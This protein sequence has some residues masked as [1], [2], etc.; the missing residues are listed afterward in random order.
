M[1]FDYYP[2]NAVRINRAD[3]PTIHRL[4]TLESIPDILSFKLLQ[5]WLG[6]QTDQ[7]MIVGLTQ[8]STACPISNI[9]RHIYQISSTI[10]IYSTPFQVTISLYDANKPFRKEWKIKQ[11]LF[12]VI[13]YIDRLHD[14]IRRE[15][16]QV[17]VAEL[18]AIVHQVQGEYL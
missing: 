14:D 7:N 5:E 18:Q 8:A 16:H 3:L 11:A 13:T 2:R 9:V 12:K 10:W 4:S 1:R 6:L 15:S 17:T